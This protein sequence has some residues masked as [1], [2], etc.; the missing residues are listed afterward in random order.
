MSNNNKNNPNRLYFLSQTS[1]VI[2][3]HY[4]KWCKN[5]IFKMSKFERMSVYYIL[6]HLEGSVISKSWRELQH[7]PIKTKM[8]RTVFFTSTVYKAQE[9][10]SPLW[11]IFEKKFRTG[12][13]GEKGEN[14]K[15]QAIQNDTARK[16]INKEKCLILILSFSLKKSCSGTNIWGMTVF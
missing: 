13:V 14:L 16:K 6:T 4:I 15:F 5:I 3:L 11:I 9:V 7:E 1:L 8:R 12:W 10:F 2:H